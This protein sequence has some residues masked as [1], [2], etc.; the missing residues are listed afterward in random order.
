MSVAG[1]SNNRIHIRATISHIGLNVAAI[2]HP[3]KG[4]RATHHHR[5]TSSLMATRAKV[6]LVTEKR[7]VVIEGYVLSDA[8]KD[9]FNQVGNSGLVVGIGVG[10]HAVGDNGTYGHCLVSHQFG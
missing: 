9:G 1:G 7:A 10:I 4:T 3:E 8:V 5:P 2:I 6:E